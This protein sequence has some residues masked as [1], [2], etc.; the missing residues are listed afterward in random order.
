M[1]NEQRSEGSAAGFRAP[2]TEKAIVIYKESWGFRL[3][4]QH[5][6]HIN[7]VDRLVELATPGRG[8]TYHLERVEE[9]EAEYR[10]YVGG[11]YGISHGMSLTG[12]TE[13][14]FPTISEELDRLRAAWRGADLRETDFNSWAQ[15]A[16][17]SSHTGYLRT[18]IREARQA[19]PPSRDQA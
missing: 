14:P 7:E 16:S 8:A 11:P 2:A 1:A 12:P 10:V 9:T 6:V 13:Y 17:H 19:G 5:M 18:R 15:G 4:D 3:P